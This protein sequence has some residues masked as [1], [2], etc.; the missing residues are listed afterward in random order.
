MSKRSK[1][2][3]KQKQQRTK[4]RAMKSPAT[5]KKKGLAAFQRLEYSQA[6]KLWEHLKLEAEP[7]LRPA[8]AEAYFRHALTGGVRPESR[9]DLQHALELTPQDGRLHYYLGLA[10]HSAGKP[11]KALA[12]YARAAELGYS[13]AGLGFA[14]ALADFVRET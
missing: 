1:R 3:H 5:V 2:K 8:L 12:A 14:K 6:I 11:A 9:T 4:A 7:E 13:G 10:H